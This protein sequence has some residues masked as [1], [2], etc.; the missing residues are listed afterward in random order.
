MSTGRAEAF[1][2]LIESLKN[3]GNN[4]HFEIILFTQL[5][6]IDKPFSDISV[7]ELITAA[8]RASEIQKEL[9]EK[10]LPVVPQPRP[11]R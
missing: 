6:E 7:G 10:R 5:N 3:I 4:G 8:K 2:E 11:Q 9:A 1:I